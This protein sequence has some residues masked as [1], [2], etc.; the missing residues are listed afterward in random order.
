WIFINVSASDLNKDSVKLY[1]NGT[2]EDFQNQS[3]DIY[4]SNKTGLL[5]GNYIFYAWLNDSTGN[6][7]QTETRE[8]EINDI[9]PPV[10]SNPK[11]TNNSI[12][13]GGNKSLT[14]VVSTDETAECRYSTSSGTAFSSMTPFTNTDS[15]THNSTLIN[16]TDGSSYNYYIKCNDTNGNV[17]IDDYL[18]HFNVSQNW[19][20]DGKESWDSYYGDNWTGI[21]ESNNVNI[22]SDINLSEGSWSYSGYNNWSYRQEINISNTGE[23]LTNYQVKV[24]Y[25]FSTEYSAGKINTTCKDIRFTYYNA[26]ADSET[27]IP[28]WVETCNFLS[29]DNMT[30]W[31]N[32]TFLE[33][34]TN[35]T[36]YMY[37]G[38]PS[39]S[40]ASNGTNTFELFDDFEGTS[41]D[42]MSGG[43]DD[44]TTY[45]MMN[46]IIRYGSKTHIC[47][48]KYE[49]DSYKVYVRTY[50]HDT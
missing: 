18:I 1:W 48:S 23:N 33:D 15:L 8:V 16:L 4:W 49:S 32:V 2:M 9:T 47:Y 20:W 31:V 7:N 26:T 35:T 42:Y 28:F 3:G 27:E 12:V 43:S 21:A 34:N 44:A 38:N 13:S 24:V 5:N 17:N 37:Y 41:I 19:W 14:F 45:E 40:S 25:N 30:T 6:T 50:H 46:K 29:S 36:I 10:I 22:G 11:P 39:A